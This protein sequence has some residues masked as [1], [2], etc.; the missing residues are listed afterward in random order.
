MSISRTIRRKA[1]RM[2]A[3]QEKSKRSN[4]MDNSRNESGGKFTII[5]KFTG[6]IRSGGIE[7]LIEHDETIR[8]ARQAFLD[9]DNPC[10]LLGRV[11]QNEGAFTASEIFRM[12]DATFECACFKSPDV[13]YSNQY[14]LALVNETGGAT[15]TDVIYFLNNF[16]HGL[17][18]SGERAA[19]H[20]GIGD[21]LKEAAMLSSRLYCPES[22]DRLDDRDYQDII[23]HVVNHPHYAQAMAWYE[24][25][26]GKKMKEMN[27]AKVIEKCAG[28][29][30]GGALC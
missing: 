17:R 29:K 13:W 12:V 22:L 21:W 7:L 25:Y 18:L 6:E 20:L 16:E 28:L 24:K 3:K 4:T 26:S 19:R 8:R 10:Y 1:E 5:D 14:A 30:K 9:S 11:Q 23:V 27:A 2:A 15:E